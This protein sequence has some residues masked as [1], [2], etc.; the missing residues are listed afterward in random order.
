MERWIRICFSDFWWLKKK[1]KKTE[2]DKC[3]LS[4][5]NSLWVVVLKVFQRVRVCFQY[6]YDSI[7][8]LAA[9]FFKFCITWGFFN[10]SDY[11]ICC[12]HLKEAKSSIKTQSLLYITNF[13][14]TVDLLTLF[15]Y[16][17]HTN[18]WSIPTSKLWIIYIISWN[19]TIMIDHSSCHS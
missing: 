12:K 1:K 2:K 14:I 8:L 4:S 5:A 19:K 11:S 15:W 3:Q 13:A 7:Y 10:A 16:T 17:W 9:A 18:F 6:N